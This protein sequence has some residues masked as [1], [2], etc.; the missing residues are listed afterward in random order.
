VRSVLRRFLSAALGNAASNP[1][2]AIAGVL[3]VTLGT[4]F[5]S[6]LVALG[7][8]A[9][10]KAHIPALQI[11]FLRYVGGL[12]AMVAIVACSGW[13][14]VRCGTG[15]LAAH[16]A[17][18]GF[19]A[20]GVVCSLYAA[21]HMPLADATAIGLTQGMFVVALAVLFL[22]ERVRLAQCFAIGMCA[23]GAAIIILGKGVAWPPASAH[24]W[25][26]AMALAGALLI[27]AE[28]VL[29]RSL[30]VRDSAIAVLFFV[31]LFA[32]LLLLT[33]ALMVW[34][35]V[36]I[37]EAAGLMLLGPLAIVAQYFNIRGYRL[38]NASLL[39]PV[40]YSRLVF[41]A[42]LG[43]TLFG[44]K[45]SLSTWLGGAII[46]VSGLVL[47]RLHGRDPKK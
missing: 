6:L 20:A 19:G 45:P 1:S 8:L 29:I 9:G 24:A 4:F 37:S 17:R 46:V 22:K 28:I 3:W 16:A 31:N 7:K 42:A 39:G 47:V 36:S 2:P 13:G 12:I 5:F 27:A 43:F 11:V 44:E 10:V 21:M 23:A 25:P 40:G 18:A 14:S 33:P 32:S 41:A 26:S 38:A 15:L 30:A 34:R 35:A